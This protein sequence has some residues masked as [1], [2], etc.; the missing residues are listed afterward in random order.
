M[1]NSTPLWLDLKKEYIDDNF[2]KLL[3]Y[4]RD[5]STK[6]DSFYEQTLDLLRQRTLLLIEELAHRPL[7]QN[8]EMTDSRVFNIRLLAAWLLADT[9]GKDS[10]RT[11]I[12]MLGELRME[13]PKFS[14]DLLKLATDCL[15]YERVKEGG[16]TWDDI[17]D[18]KKE[19]FCFKVI[20]NHKL[21]V[22]RLKER[23]WKGY[24]TVGATKEREP[25][26]PHES[27]LPSLDGGSRPADAQRHGTWHCRSHTQTSGDGR[28]HDSAQRPHEG[29]HL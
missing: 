26:A 20:N 29:D 2:E 12:A 5:K 1:E 7:S 10:H 16:Y 18:F 21:M 22:P 11:F 19:V 25:E 23:Y 4:L 28:E 3:M 17:I 13:I 24:G 15:R 27:Q 8:E 6:K 14:E 9:E